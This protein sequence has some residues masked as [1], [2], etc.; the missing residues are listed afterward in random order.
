MLKE[1]DL[2]IHAVEATLRELPK[3]TEG[4]RKRER[5]KEGERE[6]GK[7]GERK[8]E[9]EGERKRGERL[10]YK[11]TCTINV[12]SERLSERLTSKSRYVE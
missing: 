11:C 6:R 4:E 10:A 5:G 7:E 12:S 1:Q 3:K 8:R 2:I 9:R